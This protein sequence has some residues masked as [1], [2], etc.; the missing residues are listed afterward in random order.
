[1]NTGPDVRAPDDDQHG[2]APGVDIRL[3]FIGRVTAVREKGGKAQ[4]Q[5]RA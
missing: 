2:G 4:Y 1:M 3:L 5:V